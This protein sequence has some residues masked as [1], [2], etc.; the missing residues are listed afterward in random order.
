MVRDCPVAQTVKN[1]P[2]T[3]ETRVRS[4]DQED[5]LEK[6]MAAHST[7]LAWGTPMDREAWQATVHRFTKNW[8]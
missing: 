7:I 3:Q 2:A 4:L 5:L 8:T 1:L 6:E